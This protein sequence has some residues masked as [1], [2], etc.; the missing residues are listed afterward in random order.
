MGF[1]ILQTTQGCKIFSK[2]CPEYE[3]K[4]LKRA[5][6]RKTNKHGGKQ[7]KKS[8]KAKKS[9]RKYNSKRSKSYLKKRSVLSMKPWNGHDSFE[10][11]Q[12]FIRNF[13]DQQ[14]SMHYILSDKFMKLYRDGNHK[15]YLKKHDISSRQFTHDMRTLHAYLSVA[16][17]KYTPTRDILYKY[18]T[19]FKG[20]PDGIKAYHK[21]GKTY[22]L[23]GAAHDQQ[24]V[25]LSRRRA[26]PYY[27]GFKGGLRS[28][29]DK[30][31][32][33]C[34]E[35]ARFRKLIACPKNGTRIIAPNC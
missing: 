23:G 16:Y 20:G 14:P 10:D 30:F 12:N 22:G 9:S 27:D 34:S 33:T 35:I 26:L 5:K 28:Y 25:E 29:V 32:A 6:R 8:R 31:Q 2:T 24:Y 17:E 4:A 13:V 7:S 3:K 11:T 15:D 18:R 1:Y 21:L 19:S